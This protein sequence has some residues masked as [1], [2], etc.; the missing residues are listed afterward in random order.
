MKKSYSRREFFKNNSLAA[1]GLLSMGTLA[2]SKKHIYESG[3]KQICDPESINTLAG[4]PLEKLRDKYKNELFNRFLP[5]MNQFAIDHE[6]G[7]VMCNLDVRTGELSNDEKRSWFVG[8]GLWVYSWLYNHIEQNE[9]YLEIA[10]KSKD[11]ALKV[12]P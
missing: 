2:G 12:R 5:N 1:L 3:T 4:M 8:R 7:G 6:Y 10:R 9:Q 11:L